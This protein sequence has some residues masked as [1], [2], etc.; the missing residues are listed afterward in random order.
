MHSSRKE[1]G[2]LLYTPASEARHMRGELRVRSVVL[3]FCFL[4][5]FWGNLHGIIGAGYSGVFQITEETLL[6]PLLLQAF[7]TSANEQG[8]VTLQW[9]TER[10]VDLI[11]FRLYRS[12]GT[13]L[14]NATMINSTDIPATNTSS[15]QSYSFED[16]VTHQPCTL[17]Y[18]LE[19][20][21]HFGTEIA[22]PQSV[23]IQDVPRLRQRP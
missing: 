21:G 22:G 7:T 13:D 17:Y 12:T 1:S 14:S 3:F 18:W 4:T 11:K 10:E 9:T 8:R 16:P 19:I 2:D 23:T 15:A 6:S 20:V 5:I